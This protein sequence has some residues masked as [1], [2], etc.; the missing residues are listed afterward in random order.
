MISVEI[1]NQKWKIMLGM[2]SRIVLLVCSAKLQFCTKNYKV[3]DK[4]SISQS[5][6]GNRKSVEKM[7][8]SAHK[9]IIFPSNFFSFQFIILK[10]F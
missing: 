4:L 9:S 7:V 2:M 1:G 6:A 8:N 5:D 3:S 10:K